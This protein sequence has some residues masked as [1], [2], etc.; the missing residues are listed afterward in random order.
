[1]G[2]YLTLPTVKFDWSK[3]ITGKDRKLIKL[4]EKNELNPIFY[5]AFVGAFFLS[6]IYWLGIRCTEIFS[7]FP[8]SMT[9]FIMFIAIILGSASLFFKPPK[10]KGFMMR[11]V[12]VIVLALIGLKREIDWDLGKH[13]VSFSADDGGKYDLQGRIVIVTGANSGVGM[14]SSELF[15]SYGA[16]VIMACRNQERCNNAKNI[17]V[18]NLSSRTSF[19]GPLIPTVIDL[20]NLYSVKNFT[21]KIKNEYNNIDILINNAGSIPIPGERTAQGLEMSWGA[22]HIGHFALTK[23]LLPQLLK[24]HPDAIN[25]KNSIDSDKESCDGNSDGDNDN[26]NDNDS[27]LPLDLHA[28][29]I[30]KYHISDSARIVYVTSDA[31]LAGS[32]HDSLLNGNYTGAG[33][34]HGELI[35]NCPVHLPC[36]PI[37]SCPNTNSYARAKLSNLLHSYELQKKI[38]NYAI[39]KPIDTV[40]RIVTSSLHPGAVATNIHPF[41]SNK[42]TNWAMR[43]SMEAASIVVYAAME[44]K[45]VPSS[46]IDSTCRPHD[47][48]EYFNLNA[49]SNA[50]TGGAITDSGG[51]GNGNGD[52]VE[53]SGSVSVSGGINKHTDVWPEAKKLPFYQAASNEYYKVKVSSATYAPAAGVKEYTIGYHK[54]LFN[55]KS[56]LHSD[57][58]KWAI[59]TFFNT[60]PLSI[61]TLILSILRN[62]ILFIHSIIRNI[63]YFNVFNLHYTYQ[64]IINIKNQYNYNLHEKEVVSARLWDVSMA[65]VE[66]FEK[67]LPSADYL[68]DIIPQVLSSDTPLKL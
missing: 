48:F 18:K 17:I 14:S 32:F 29:E 45:F 24:P 57:N 64:D 22:M 41:F 44:D 5:W 12:T 13:V 7:L 67:G 53:G 25:K 8:E 55:S 6:I 56:F 23:W 38:D 37:G 42:L 59:V 19:V 10:S 65:I 47:L 9:H 61:F 16:T 15:A 62:I 60:L 52:N 4:E 43:S 31:F 66:S 1:M 40:R 2:N 46:F 50:N 21:N 63:D 11:R 36:C 58:D 26:D 35:D 51:N 27:D 49:N 28:K 30:E 68:N 33:D 39:N 34:L 54:Y 3:T 20:S